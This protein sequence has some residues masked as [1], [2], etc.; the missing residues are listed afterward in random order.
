MP[1][2]RGTELKPKPGQVS[3]LLTTLAIQS[4]QPIDAADP[5]KGYRIRALAA[6]DKINSGRIRIRASAW[7]FRKQGAPMLYEHG[8]DPRIGASPLG[9]WDKFEVL[10][11]T[12]LVAEGTV[13]YFEAPDPRAFV[14]ADINAGRLT[15]VSVGHAPS[16][17]EIAREQGEQYLDVQNT[18]LGE[19]SV[20]SVGLDGDATFELMVASAFG[21]E[22]TEDS[23]APPQQGGTMDK[24]LLIQ[25]L[26]MAGQSL[27]EDA[28]D[29]EIVTAVQRMSQSAKLGVNAEAIL[30]AVGLEQGAT[31]DTVKLRIAEIRKP[32]GFVPVAEYE[33]LR[34]Q[35]TQSATDTLIAQ[36]K[37]IPAGQ[38]EFAK[39][40]LAQGVDPTKADDPGRK[41]FDTWVQALPSLPTR[42]YTGSGSGTPP[43]GDEREEDTMEEITDE[44]KHWCQTLGYFRDERDPKTGKVT[45][46]GFEV[47]AQMAEMTSQ[48][49]LS[50]LFGQP[51][52]ET[53]MDRAFRAQAEQ[54]R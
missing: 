18:T 53:A 29:A 38:V 7:K 44:D 5:H 48:E 51:V 23:G 34:Q 14:V 35:L 52:P 46:R 39:T 15:D 13:D 17:M 4:L 30:S 3:P 31:L 22:W 19:I 42:S 21:Y 2:K 8:K 24:K 36:H 16:K 37:N 12:G 11:G 54:Q 10:E 45:V 49:G 20:V 26:N 33:T 43:K 28:S 1:W 50:L 25:L 6:S 47:M 40:L 32:E 27:K 9:R 41:M